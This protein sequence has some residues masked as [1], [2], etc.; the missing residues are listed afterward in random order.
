MSHTNCYSN[1]E[2][3]ERQITAVHELVQESNHEPR[4]KYYNVFL[5]ILLASGMIFQ[6]YNYTIF[7]PLGEPMIKRVYSLNDEDEITRICAMINLLYCLGSIIGCLIGG[8]LSE[9]L[10]RL[11]SV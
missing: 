3:I 7:N 6:G 1:I 10:G 9:A 11:K 4:N 5:A 8:S 2:D